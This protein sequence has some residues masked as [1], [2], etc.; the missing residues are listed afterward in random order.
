MAH[1]PG[2]LVMT[3]VREVLGARLDAFV[4]YGSSA[5]GDLLPGYSD[6]DVLIALNEPITLAD[7][8][9]LQHAVEAIALEPY[10]Y[11]QPTFVLGEPVRPL[12]SPGT[13]QV[14]TGAISQERWVC[15]ADDLRARS[16]A[17]LDDLP[18]LV[19]SDA[20]DWAM[21]TRALLRR[22]A[23]L[24]LTRVKPSLRALLVR[25]GCEPVR[26][27]AGTWQQIATWL[28]PVD[29]A[30]ADQVDRLLQEARARRDRPVAEMALRVLSR[31]CTEHLPEDGS[32][33][34]LKLSS[35][36]RHSHG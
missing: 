15:R 7:T 20:G 35:P 19:T 31:V 33:G 5:S 26:A 11:C 4:L 34:Y 32:G 14:L 21:T 29:E 16:E 36:D 18:R 13:F 25:A 24:H 28:T 17:W 30:L 22:Q 3:A 27:W 2:G 6:L 8:L 12:L 10:S 23:R 1:D 9:A